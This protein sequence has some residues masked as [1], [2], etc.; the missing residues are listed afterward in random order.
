TDISISINALRAD[1]P[2]DIEHLSNSIY[3]PKVG[4]SP[5]VTSPSEFK[6]KPKNY[7]QIQLDETKANSIYIANYFNTPVGRKLR[8]SL[9]VG[10]VIPL[11]SKSQLLKAIFFLPDL[12]TQAELI[13]VDNKIQQ[14]SF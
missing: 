3:L 11:I 8:E 2:E 6:I 1:N 7:Y 9:E 13:E 14:F 10:A 5:V 12:Q 4:N